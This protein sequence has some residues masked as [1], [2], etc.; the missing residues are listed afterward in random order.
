MHLFKYFPHW[1]N[2]V[3]TD[4]LKSVYILLWSLLLFIPGIIAAYSYSMTDYI[5]AEHPE[6]TAGAAI[7]ASKAMMSGNKWRLFCLHVSFIG[8]EFLCAFTFGIGNLWLNPYKKAATAAFY[9]EVSGTEQ[10]TTQPVPV[11]TQPPTTVAP[12][13]PQATTV[14]MAT[15]APTTAAPETTVPTTV[16]TPVT[17]SAPET[18]VPVTTAAPTQPPEVP[19]EP[20]SP[21]PVIAATA[22]AVT[23]CGGGA[24]LWF[25]QK[26]W[27]LKLLAKLAGK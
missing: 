5:L 6:M 4:L 12:T 20:A 3:C 15:A 23:V 16:T 10:P 1:A 24:Y 14:P 7:K 27:L 8:W 11:V 21:A 26:K 25:F 18:T 19:S 9:R 2:A 22:A 13:T 17:T